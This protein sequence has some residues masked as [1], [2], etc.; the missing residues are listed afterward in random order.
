MQFEVVQERMAVDFGAAIRFETLSY[1]VA[2]RM[3]AEGAIIMNRERQVEV[4]TRSDGALFG[5]F[6][7]QWRLQ[8]FEKE[9]PGLTDAALTEKL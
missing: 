4:L 6:S 7:T 5:L 3:S 2:R 9:H 1:Q 8:T